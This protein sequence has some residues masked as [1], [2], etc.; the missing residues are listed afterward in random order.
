MVDRELLT[1]LVRYGAPILFLAQV[2]GIFGL[3]IPDELLL[4]LAGA[5]VANG[6]L[7]GWPVVLAS[8]AGCLC[9]ITLSYVVGRAI[10]A[11]ALDRAARHHRK[12]VDRAQS[13]FRRFG[14]WL[15]AFG[16]FI[17]GVRHVTAIIAGSG[18]L[19][20]KTFMRFAYP[21]GVLWCST[22]LTLG[23]LAGDRWQ[24]V[25]E[26]ARAHAPLA[27]VLILCAFVAYVLTRA[28]KTEV[29]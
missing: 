17:P 7:H 5:L 9:G 13:W 18:C 27:A 3:P 2:F 16:Y 28:T 26:R 14:T 20:V 1:W 6:E 25:F 15:L 21:G 8:I 24:E 11:R 4:V 23:Y 19:N 10:G 22:F 12:G 29:Q